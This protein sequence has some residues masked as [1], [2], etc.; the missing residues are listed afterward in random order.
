MGMKDG[1]PDFL[2]VKAPLEYE[3]EGGKLLRPYFPALG[4][5][6]R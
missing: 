6:Y 1:G 5:G 4:F 2:N 3:I